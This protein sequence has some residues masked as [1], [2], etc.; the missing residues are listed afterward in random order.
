M[1]RSSRILWAILILTVLLSA[2][3]PNPAAPSE[4][5]TPAVTETSAPTPTVTP[6]PAAAMVNGEMV[7]LSDFQAEIQRIKAAAVETDNAVD[8]AALEQQALEELIGQTLLAQ[9]AVKNG[10]EMT[11]AQL[12]ER[13]A[14]LVKE[15]GGEQ[16]FQDWLNRNQYDTESFA[17]ALRRSVAA[18]WQLEKIVASVPVEAE[19]VNALQIFV[20]TKQ[21]ADRAL[22]RAQQSGTDF[23]SLAK[24]YD[25]L[26]GGAL[27]WF[28]KGYLLRP[29]VE[30]AAFALQ[31]GET[32]A[33]VT[34]EIG[35]HI[36][37]VVDR[38]DSRPLDAQA[39]QALQQ[40]AM[41]TWMDTQR[42]AAAVEVLVP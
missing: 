35:F 24:R 18:A 25:P 32:S 9:E 41:K 16:A 37:Y 4:T 17:R 39:R 6:L 15:N 38:V 26:T 28:P 8:D 10:F 23:A 36:L 19:Q 42:A 40:K 30:E 29:E 13:I 7:L 21:E 34:S 2:C 11:D 20:R 14:N 5:P 33:I 1:M 12:M 22:D 3:N 27:G 31:P